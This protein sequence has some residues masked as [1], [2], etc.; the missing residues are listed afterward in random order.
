[1][2]LKITILMELINQLRLEKYPEAVVIFLAGSVIRGEGT[3]TSDLDLVVMYE[4]LPNAYRDSFLYRGWP[5]EVFVHDPE[6]LKYFMGEIDRPSGVPAL[7]NMVAE[8][9]EI[10]GS[11][12]FSQHIKA[13]AAATLH[14]GPLPWTQQDIDAS[15]YLISDLVEDIRGVL[16]K[17]ELNATASVLY[18]AIAN[19][20]FRSNGLWSA[21]GKT[22]PR[23]LLKIDREFA[24]R[25]AAAFD[26]AFA[27]SHP[28]G[29][30]ELAKDLLD[31]Y[32]GFYFEGNRMDAPSDWRKG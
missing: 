25:F 28:D 18:T 11:S 14:A 23:R 27:Y 20:Y 2:D 17:D 26:Q 10:P 5:V 24:G 32:G 8:G 7:A 16:N 9:A 19:H 21:K 3:S 15:R 1:M 12:G 31:R 6:T 22:I 30:V 13:M 4:Q 29:I